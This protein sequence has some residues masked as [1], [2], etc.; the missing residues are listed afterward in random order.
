MH[1]CGAVCVCV[2]VCVCDW[3]VTVQTTRAAARGAKGGPGVHHGAVDHVSL[4][5][6]FVWAAAVVIAHRT[7]SNQLAIQYPK[8]KNNK[9]L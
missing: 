2:C 4:H 5:G 7:Q 9:Q 1:A 8:A 6:D 3:V